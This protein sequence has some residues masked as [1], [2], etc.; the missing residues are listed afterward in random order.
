MSVQDAADMKAPSPSREFGLEPHAL[1]QYRALCD[2]T[3]GLQQVWIFG[4]RARDDWRER[5]D[6][7]LAVDAPG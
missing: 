5:S 1:Q 2:N 7:D 6:I 4:S 3:P